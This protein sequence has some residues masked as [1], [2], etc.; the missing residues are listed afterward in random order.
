MGPVS[1]YDENVKGGVWRSQGG[2]P[3][4]LIW[5]SPAAA[6]ARRVAYNCIES[7]R[8]RVEG[9]FV[10]GFGIKVL[11]LIVMEPLLMVMVVMTVAVVMML[12]VMI[13]LLA[14]FA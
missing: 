7:V 14:M 11:A 12:M 1:G 5:R 6:L 4:G 9:E 2:T 8:K 13:G 3:P 10:M